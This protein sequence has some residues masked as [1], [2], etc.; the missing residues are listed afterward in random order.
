MRSV[1]GIDPGIHGAI[2]LYDGASLNVWDSPVYEIKTNGKT[3]RDIDM[4]AYASILVGYRADMIWLE[5]VS[6]R[7]TDG[8]VGAFKFGRVACV[9]E[10]IAVTLGLPITRVPPQVWK[11]RLG[12]PAEKD[13]ARHRASQ[14]LPD[15]AGLWT[16][17]KDD[18]RAEAAMIA[19]YGF[20]H[21]A[22]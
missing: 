14:L 13:G 16:R 3:R 4:R 11:K 7:P 2:A 20:H 9:P 19:Y 17:V 1:L 12:V 22:T 5:Q 15:Y 6:S 10:C 21:D 18:G 8:H